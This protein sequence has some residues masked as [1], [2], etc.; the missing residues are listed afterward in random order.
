[1]TTASMIIS[2]MPMPWTITATPEVGRE[3]APHPEDTA[4]QNVCQA[5]SRRQS[6][7]ECLSRGDAGSSLDLEGPQKVELALHDRQETV[8]ATMAW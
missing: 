1:M 4:A 2:T 6:G 8:V 5:K 3:K 7:T